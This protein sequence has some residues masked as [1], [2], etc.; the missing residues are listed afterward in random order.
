MEVPSAEKSKL[1]VRRV[2][3]ANR[4]SS[5]FGCQQEEGTTM[6]SGN[7]NEESHRNP[8][9]PTSG[10]KFMDSPVLLRDDKTGKINMRS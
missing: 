3:K 7:F 4:E 2:S 8:V 5:M 1:E 10:R 9:S 6:L